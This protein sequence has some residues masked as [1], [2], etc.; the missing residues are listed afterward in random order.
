M[1]D[2]TLLYVDNEVIENNVKLL[3]K[4]INKETK[5]I[6]VIKANGYG[7]GL[8]EAGCYCQDHSIADILAVVSVSEAITLRQNKIELP[9]LVLGPVFEEDF[10]LAVSYDL[11]IVLF[12]YAYASLV[13]D[14]ALKHQLK[15]KC[16][17]KVNTGL[18]RLGFDDQEEILKA[19]AFNGL[20]IEGIYSHF[21]S[22]QSKDEDEMAF[23]QFQIEKFRNVLAFLQA[24]RLDVGLTHM[25]NSP[26]ILKYGDLG[27]DAV[28]CGMIIFGLFHP[29]QREKAYKL[30]F[31]NPYSLRSRICLVR[32]IK[33]GEGVG[34][35]RSYKAVKDMKIA[36]VAGGY[37]DGILRQ[38]SLNHGK[39]AINHHHFSILGD[40]AMSQYMIDCGDYP[41]KLGDEV[42][43]F[44]AKDESI[45]DYIDTSGQT[46]NEFISALRPTVP[47]IYQN[48]SV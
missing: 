41:F 47:R 44:D 5:V 18:N 7:Y 29:E 24:K 40:I 12:D 38:Y 14:F 6:A 28:R 15:V 13:N 39:L 43:Y 3:R 23:T 34:Y 36:T 42:R 37:C 48:P 1:S 17:L 9:I 31:R 19:Y 45:Y 8:A 4:I 16:H 21:A 20:L 25:Q 35:G 22:A 27:F 30:G 10:M 33:A 2:G 11:T 32:T 26:S 46:I